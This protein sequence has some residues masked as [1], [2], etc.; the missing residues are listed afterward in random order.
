MARPRGAVPGTVSMPHIYAQMISNG[1]GAFL[2]LFYARLLACC[3]LQREA[4]LSLPFLFPN[5]WQ[6]FGAVS[7]EIPFVGCYLYTSP[8]VSAV[9]VGGRADLPLS[10]VLGLV[11]FP[12]VRHAPEAAATESGTCRHLPA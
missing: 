10:S 9:D 4:S 1:D 11:Q 12:H 8:C 5:A 3:S 6:N 2:S 7:H